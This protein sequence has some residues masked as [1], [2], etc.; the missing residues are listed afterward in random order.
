MGLNRREFIKLTAAGSALASLSGCTRTLIQSS[1]N[2][3]RVVIIGGG[4]AGSTVAKYLRN[5]S[6]AG[7]ETVVIEPEP[8]FISC[9]LSNLVLGGSKQL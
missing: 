5:W 2:K 8:Y 4:Y 9:P 6:N 7:I 3:P 1:G